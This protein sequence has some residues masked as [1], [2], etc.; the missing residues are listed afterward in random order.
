LW[1]PFNP[2]SALTGCNS[3][4]GV[5]LM[6]KPDP[7]V[8]EGRKNACKGPGRRSRKAA[9]IESSEQER[10]P[11]GDERKASCPAAA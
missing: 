2:Q 3:D 11:A 10:E 9:P 4:R 5:G 1:N 8:D 6:E 7:Q